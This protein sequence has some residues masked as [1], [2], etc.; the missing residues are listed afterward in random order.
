MTTPGVIAGNAV[1]TIITALHNGHNWRLIRVEPISEIE[2]VMTFQ[3]GS[4]LRYTG[5]GDHREYLQVSVVER[6]VDI[7]V[8]TS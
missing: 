4:D 3:V 2:S 8:T 7:E 1:A 5:G 6:T